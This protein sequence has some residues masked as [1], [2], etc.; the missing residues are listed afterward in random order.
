MAIFFLSIT[1]ELKTVFKLYRFYYSKTRTVKPCFIAQD[2][3][4]ILRGTSN[5]SRILGCS[6]G[7][8][9]LHYQGVETMNLVCASES[10]FEVYG[11]FFQFYGFNQNG[12]KKVELGAVF[13]AGK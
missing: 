1:T 8:L 2:N 3:N 5:V 11:E 12:F 9:F 10:I 6:V 4:L 13:W 7:S